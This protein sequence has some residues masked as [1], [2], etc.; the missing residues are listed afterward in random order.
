MS[1]SID[2]AASPAAVFAVIANPHRHSDFDG[3]GTVQPDITGPK[4][5]NLGDTFVVQ[6]TMG[7]SRYKTTN[8]IV[9]FEQDRLIAWKHKAPQIWRYILEPI[10]SGTRVTEVFDYSGYGPTAFIFR[11]LFRKN[12]HS[13][14]K[15]L[16]RLKAL[17]ESEASGS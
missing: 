14:D 5:L 1:S 7:R 10:V 8:K 11:F 12:Q 2:I 6:M 17:V 4:Q 15:T 13:L 9:E 16:P 3:S